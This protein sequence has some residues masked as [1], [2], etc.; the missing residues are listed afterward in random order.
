[1]LFPSHM[2]FCC[3]LNTA[4]TRAIATS[5]LWLLFVTVSWATVCLVALVCLP[6]MGTLGN[7]ASNPEPPLGWCA[8]QPPSQCLSE[9]MLLALAVCP[10]HA[11]AA[12]LL[13]ALM[14]ETRPVYAWHWLNL[15][16]DSIPWLSRTTLL[17]W[18]MLTHDEVYPG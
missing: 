7:P 13:Q 12:E 15:Q 10:G 16:P 3:L 8:P 18:P 1:M 6:S 4:S 5:G 14:H 9:A 11:A 17:C 2:S